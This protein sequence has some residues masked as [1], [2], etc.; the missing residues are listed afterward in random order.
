MPSSSV[1]KAQSDQPGRDGQSRELHLVMDNYAAHKRVEVRD[2]LAAHPRIHAHFT[3]QRLLADLV[4][5]CF[6][7]IERPAIHRGTEHHRDLQPPTAAQGATGRE[8]PSDLL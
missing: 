3:H 2:R 1:A 5:A 7:I 4:K 6:G 8:Q